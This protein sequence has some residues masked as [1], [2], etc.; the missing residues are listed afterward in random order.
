MAIENYKNLIGTISSS[1]YDIKESVKAVSLRKL[2]CITGLTA[3]SRNFFLTYLLSEEE[4]PVLLL[5][6]DDVTALKIKND[7]QTFLGDEIDVLVGQESSPYELVYSDGNIAYMQKSVLNNFRSGKLKC[8]VVSVKNL[9]NTYMPERVRFDN[10]IKLEKDAEYDT[11]ELA[12]KLVKIGY[13]RVSMVVDPGEFS[14][15]G[16]IMDI[17][18]ISSHPVRIEFFADQVE[19]IKL[20][21]IDNQRSIK[22]IE[23]VTIEPRYNLVLTD[24]H[25]DLIINNIIN[26]NNDAFDLSQQATETLAQTVEN[27]V[28]LAESDSYFEG[29]EYFAPFIYDKPA[30]ITSYLPHNALVVYLE[31]HEFI[32]KLTLQDDKLGRIYE[33][34]CKEGLIPALPGYIH[35]AAS[36]ILSKL[37]VF[38]SLNLDSFV[39]DDVK[40]Y[41]EINTSMVPKFLGNLPD[42]AN[43]ILPRMKEGYRLIVSTDYPGR[44]SEV[45]NEYDC[46]CKI[47]LEENYDEFIFSKGVVYV[48]R[49]LFSEGFVIEDEKFVVI[50]DAEL[51][52]KKSKK[53]TA[54]KKLSKRENLDFLVSVNELSPGDYVVHSK[55]G[56]GKF[57][58][59][60][61][62]TIDGQ[63]RD[64]LTIEYSGSDRLHMPAEQ[65]NFLARYRGAGVPP[66]LSKMG[67]ADWAKVKNKVEKA[68]KDIAQDLI[69]LYAKRAKSEGFAFDQD[70]AWQLEMEDSFPYTETPD[71]LQ[72]INDIKA[73]MESTN[74]TDRLI[75]GD[76]GFGKTEVAIRAVFKAIMSGKQVAVVAPTTILAQQHYNNFVERFKPY[77]I[78][79]DLLS[80][81][82]TP[83]FQRETIKNLLKGECD[84]V[85]GTHRVFQNDVKFKNLGLLVID[86]E[87]R[88]GVS[89][90]EKLKMLRSDV[91]VITLSATPIPR[92]LYMSLS[93]V[94]DL[95]LINTPPVNRAP[96]KTYV[97]T[98]NSSMIRTAINHELERGGQVY[99]LHNRV[100]S[101]YKV[102]DDLRQ[103][104]PEAR[105]AVGH[106][107]MGERELEKIMCD[108]GDYEYD[109]LCATTIIESGL[110]IPNANTII[111]DNADRFGLAQLYQLR[112]RVG[113]SDRQAYAYCFYHPD[114]VLESEAKERLKAIK[115]FNTLG[116]GYQ[117]AL[118]DLEIRGVGNILGSQQHGHMCAVGFDLYCSLLEDAVKEMQ[119]EKVNKKEPPVVDINI[120]AY[121]PDEWIGQKD[122][123]MIEYKRLA[124]VQSIRELEILEEEW[125][126]RF[127]D[128]PVPVTRLMN[129]I[130]IRLLAAEIGITLIREVADSIRIY[131]D[132]DLQEWR[133]CQTRLSAKYT[134]RTKWLKAPSTSKD[135]KSLI[136]LNNN[137]LLIEELLKLLEDMFVEILKIQQSF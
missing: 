13:K 38:S 66:K 32:Q 23:S 10:T 27:L 26:S 35:I 88:F 7:V 133:L 51:F 122:Q 92:T 126:D 68:V 2:S 98:Y 137:G 125:K 1:F 49:S 84:L 114:K 36:D 105:V 46:T 59:L 76:V 11:Y 124:D 96:V 100:Q 60:C 80:R 135:G 123:K 119:G 48:F 52:N 101:I 47:V 70:T 77:P 108:F 9:L 21:G 74:P 91:D 22:H 42:A 57:I 85:I 67:G 134:K 4:K 14:L 34:N 94:R 72:A 41:E 118:R 3:S 103:L 73:D 5:V 115:D 69:N 131:T 112:G 53:P 54:A 82:R 25:K 28:A 16:D 109:I 86:E 64:Y 61:K 56:L 45:L 95:S 81:F 65:I 39:G 71:Q 55:H 29:V 63:D 50:T 121:I 113:R 130:R 33:T 97:G 37:S 12:E 44:V 78:K 89:H 99:F 18:P 116:S 129:I 106:G 132:Y 127:G 19:A 62:Q 120:T 110:D 20:L 30:D 102:A 17:Y 111:I 107:Q 136:I 15:R 40:N 87:H 104:I 6:P 79:I 24:Q 75:C 58:E 128:I 93:G 90:K 117:I 43:Y 31:S 83:K 8:L